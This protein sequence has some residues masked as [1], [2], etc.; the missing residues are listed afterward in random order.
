VSLVIILLAVAL[1]GEDAVA[2]LG[3]AADVVTGGAE[4]VFGFTFTPF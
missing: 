4:F 1:V 2:A 3:A